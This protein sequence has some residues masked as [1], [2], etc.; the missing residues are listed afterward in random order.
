MVSCNSRST[1]ARNATVLIVVDTTV[2]VVVIS[3]VAKVGHTGAHA[4]PT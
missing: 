1:S 4:L 2:A 3:G